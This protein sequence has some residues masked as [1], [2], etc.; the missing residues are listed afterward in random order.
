MLVGDLT[1]A[2]SLAD[3]PDDPT[4]AGEGVLALVPYRQITERG[5]ECHDDGTPLLFLRVHRRATMSVSSA[6]DCL[7]SDGVRLIDGGFDINDEDYAEIVRRVVREEIGS[8]QGSNFVIR[9]SYSATVA[10][11]S[12]RS[13]LAM[14]RALLERESGTYWTFLVHT[15]DRVLVGAS[16]ERHVSMVDDTVLMNPISGT[17]RYPP[18]GP[19]LTDLLGFLADQKETDELYM[20][21]DEEL[22]MMTRV[23]DRE[24]RVIGPR[25]KEMAKLAHTEY[26][27]EGSTSLDPRDVLRETMFAPTVTG[28][29]VENAVRV[30][31]RYESGGRGYYSG[32]VAYLSRGADGQ[33]L[34]DSAIMIR[35]ADI[36]SAGM[37]DIGV[38]ATL[39]RHSD[40]SA[41]VAETATKVAGLLG[42]LHADRTVFPRPQASRFGTEPTVRAALARR[43][44]KLARFWLD[45]PVADTERVPHGRVL[46]V[47]AE[48]T[49]TAMLSHQLHSFG[50][51]VTVLAYPEVAG[52]P[53]QHDLV[54]LGPG[55]GDPSADTDPKIATLAGL[56]RKLLDSRFPTLAVCL[57][58]Q[59]LCR[60][61][62][63]PIVRRDVPNQGTQRELDLFGRR[64]TV[65]FYNT[66]VAVSATD[67]LVG[68]YG[69]VEV[70]RDRA[71]GEV[72]ATRGLA[73]RSLQFHPE[74]ILSEHGV[75]VLVEQLRSLLVTPAAT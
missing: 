4:S 36:D 30:I 33:C 18:A 44:A 38:G 65:G 43:N 75:S 32:V 56:T 7:P 69:K 62:G 1:T 34:L 8:G 39:V 5:F 25:L 54:V 9:R 47:D 72:Y 70:S 27:I 20:V 14:F 52:V 10:D 55:P 49:F 48:D 46:V 2:S 15:G 73:F 21:L 22:K 51:D 19:N 64:A 37:L 23:C 17:Y 31:R 41:E 24:I 59:I 58:H 60:S 6:L 42:A 35:T 16:P 53:G 29:P 71:T 3:L 40:P 66:F 74:S 67:E 63:L 61:L 50:L 13:A 28:S 45:L 26:D 11:F 57:S 68:P 12:I